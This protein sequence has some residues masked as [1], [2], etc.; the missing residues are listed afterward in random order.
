M[1]NVTPDSVIY[2]TP[3]KAEQRFLLHQQPP[4][5]VELNLKDVGLGHLVLK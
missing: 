4:R 3:K 5:Q 2:L 1:K